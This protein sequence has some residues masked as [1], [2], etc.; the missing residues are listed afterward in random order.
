MFQDG[1]GRYHRALVT[2][3]H[4]HRGS[5][6]VFRP[7]QSHW[8]IVGTPELIKVRRA[9]LIALREFSSHPSPAKGGQIEI[10][11]D[12]Q[13]G[14]GMGS[15]TSDVTATIRAIAD[16]YRVSLAAEDVA[17]LAVLAE[18]AADSIMITDRV[19]LFAHREG[20]VLET[21]GYRLPPMVVVG[22]DTRPGTI[23]DTLGFTPAEYD[24]RELGQFSVLR[25]A[26]RR[27]IATEDVALLGR[28]TTASA[29]I[30][31]R[32]LPTP[33]FES[34]LELCRR[35]GGAGI[36]VAHSGTVAGLIFDAR[37]PEV[38]L[39]VR[40]CVD[41]IGELG[42]T[43]TAMIAPPELGDIMDRAAREEAREDA[44]VGAPAR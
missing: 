2:L 15:S 25:G 24:D 34:L 30:N 12:I 27:A 14:I 28:V 33:Q 16:Y 22:C 20:F 3:P 21:L 32:F 5:R 29:R 11:S 31:Q 10:S 36:Q 9:A 18:C 41:G 17:R 19:V 35:H 38:D 7:S 4:P 40:Q 43:L 6:A 1:A 39:A 26:L 44:E 23:V 13:R 42:L 8:G 37:R